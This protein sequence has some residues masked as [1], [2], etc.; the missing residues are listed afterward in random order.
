MTQYELKSLQN[1]LLQ[2]EI[3]LTTLVVKFTSNIF[4]KNYRIIIF[5]NTLSNI[6]PIAIQMILK[7]IKK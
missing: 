5:F 2:I 6:L 7:V 1:N 3:S 4:I